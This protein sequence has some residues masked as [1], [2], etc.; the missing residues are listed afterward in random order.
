MGR[1]GWSELLPPRAQERMR[2]LVKEA[3]QTKLAT[4]HSPADQCAVLDREGRINVPALDVEV[5]G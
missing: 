2:V 1:V 5:R 4:P 3:H